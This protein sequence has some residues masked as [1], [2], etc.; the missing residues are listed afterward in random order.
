MNR[1]PVVQSFKKL[2]HFT[3]DDS[4]SDSEEKDKKEGEKKEKGSDKIEE[5]KNETAIS[6]LLDSARNRM[7]AKRLVGSVSISQYVGLVTSY[8]NCDIN[9]SVYENF[10]GDYGVI[11]IEK[12]ESLVGLASD[13]LN[14]I[15]ILISG[16][17]DRSSAW[18]DYDYT[19][20][21]TI[22]KDVNVGF[23]LPIFMTMGFAIT[24]QISCTVSSLLRYTENDRQ[25]KLI[26]DTLLTMEYGKEIVKQLVSQGISIPLAKKAVVLTSGS[27]L[28]NALK[29][30]STVSK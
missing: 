16:L 6:V 4:D 15:E 22:S 30:I 7:L 21:I 25:M 24:I 9:E 17:I 3:D 2:M 28:E 11:N 23:Y 18:V 19:D 13:A 1:F 14:A 27:S 20:D 29:Y 12:E 5:H 26:D 10:E 8:V